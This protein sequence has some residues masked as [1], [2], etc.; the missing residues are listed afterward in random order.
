M[1]I[2]DE[3]RRHLFSRSFSVCYLLLLGVAVVLS[4]QKKTIP[5]SAPIL[6]L[7]KKTI[8]SSN[9]HYLQDASCW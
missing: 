8:K 6:I 9:L 7:C 4:S 5:P 2:A 3:P 1:S